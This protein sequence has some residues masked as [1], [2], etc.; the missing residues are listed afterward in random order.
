LG[1]Q[2]S[3][4]HCQK[5]EAKE[6]KAFHNAQRSFPAGFGDVSFSADANRSPSD[7]ASPGVDP[8]ADVDDVADVDVARP[9]SCGHCCCGAPT[10]EGS[11][12]TRDESAVPAATVSAVSS[13]EGRAS[14][15]A[16]GDT[17]PEGDRS[18][19]GLVSAESA[20]AKSYPSDSHREATSLEH[21]EGALLS[22]E[23]SLGGLVLDGA[24]VVNSPMLPYVR[25]VVSLLVKESISKR[26]LV[27]ELLKIMRQ[28]SIDDRA[29]TRY[30]SRFLDQ[31]P[32]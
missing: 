14:R 8:C 4:R 19:S 13:A 20:A 23:M 10:A 22:L 31:H 18:F 29:N 26:E 3:R 32:P 27:A 6:K 28:R 9:F 25:M 15:I 12:Q 24:S 17:G 21:P 1:K 16:G 7:S 2:R 5:A 11:P 30:A